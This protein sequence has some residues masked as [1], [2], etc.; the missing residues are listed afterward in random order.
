M[1][2]QTAGAKGLGMTYEI[3]ALP[4]IKCAYWADGCVEGSSVKL[5]SGF[6]GWRQLCVTHYGV[7]NLA[8]S[9][10]FC[11]DRGLDATE[12]RIAFCR[13]LWSKQRDPRAWMKNPKSEIARRYRDEIIRSQVVSDRV[14]GEDDE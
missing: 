9:L 3:K 7:D 10:K 14:P 4:Y 8:E 5:R 12:K 6:G 13:S 2:A 11:V 1:L